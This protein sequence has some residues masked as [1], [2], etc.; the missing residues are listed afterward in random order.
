LPTL[1]DIRLLVQ[2][3]V[4]ESARRS[5]RQ[6]YGYAQQYGNQYGIYGP[7]GQGW[8]NG[9]D[10]RYSNQQNYAWSNSLNWNQ[11]NRRPEWYH[12]TGTQRQISIVHLL[13]LTG[14]CLSVS[15]G[16]FNSA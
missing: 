1:T 15:I 10:N 7:G 9:F 2:Y 13:S 12:N 8:S 4:I 5:R 6:Q 11:G 3:S 16:I 14:L